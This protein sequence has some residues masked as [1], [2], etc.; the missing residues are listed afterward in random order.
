MIGIGFAL[1]AATFLVVYGRTRAFS[2]HAKHYGRMRI[3][4]ENARR[5]LQ[6]K[7]E[8]APG[9]DV[10]RVI[11]ELGKEA[12]VENGDWVLIHRERPIEVP[13]T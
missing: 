11:L 3:L 10:R 2:E 13:R 4:F 1:I 8:N 9:V 7:K 6:E 5:R 12:L